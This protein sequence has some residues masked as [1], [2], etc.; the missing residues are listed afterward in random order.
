MICPE[1][2][3][4]RCFFFINVFN[5]EDDFSNSYSK[6]ELNWGI[7]RFKIWHEVKHIAVSPNLNP[8]MSTITVIK[9]K[10]YLSWRIFEL[11][12]EFIFFILHCSCIVGQYKYK[13]TLMLAFYTSYLKACFFCSL[14]KSPWYVPAKI[15]WNKQHRTVSK[16]KWKI[17]L[18]NSFPY[19]FLHSRKVPIFM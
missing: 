10:N 16:K 14:E 12:T 1:S 6:R 15:F 2:G 4:L 5:F 19:Q 8:S 9:I 3:S 13:N 17:Y 18:L 11:G 7:P